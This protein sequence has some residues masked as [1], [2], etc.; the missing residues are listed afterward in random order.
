MLR[1]VGG[2]PG[3]RLLPVLCFL[4]VRLRFQAS[5]VVDVTSPLRPCHCDA[6]VKRNRPVPLPVTM[7][8]CEPLFGDSGPPAVPSPIRVLDHRAVSVPAVFHQ[9]T[10]SHGQYCCR[11]LIPLIRTSGRICARWRRP[12]V[13]GGFRRF[14]GSGVF[15]TGRH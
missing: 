6:W 1:T 13:S 15:E 12:V 8:G 7:G 11:G 3:L 2:R 4:P 5:S 9:L 10:I 14:Q